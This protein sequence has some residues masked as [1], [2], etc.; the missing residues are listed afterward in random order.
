MNK[1]YT[2][3][4]KAKKIHSFREIDFEW[5]LTQKLY[6]DDVND[7]DYAKLILRGNKEH[8]MQLS[9]KALRS[10]YEFLGEVFKDE[11]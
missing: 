1:K 10:L 5:E 11:D 3:L 7:P 9:Q 4:N 6:I 2:I 8:W